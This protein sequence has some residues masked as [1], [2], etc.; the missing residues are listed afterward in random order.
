MSYIF[1][2]LNTSRH[3]FHAYYLV[4]YGSW[5]LSMFSVTATNAAFVLNLQCVCVEPSL[6]L[7]L[8]DFCAVSNIQCYSNLKSELCLLFV[9]P[10][11]DSA[12]LIATK[13]V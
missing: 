13:P 7:L 11:C 8:E 10:F 12:N 9:L 1:L 4:C 3:N 5:F 6:F 2:L